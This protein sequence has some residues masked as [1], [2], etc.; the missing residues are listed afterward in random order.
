VALARRETVPAPF[1][2]QTGTGQFKLPDLGA[3]NAQLEMIP[4][5]PSRSQ[6]RQLLASSYPLVLPYLP[7]AYE[8]GRGSGILFEAIY[9]RIPVICSEANIFTHWLREYGLEDFIFSPYNEISLAK[10]ILFF[11]EQDNIEERF[12]PLYD[13]FAAENGVNKFFDVLIGVENKS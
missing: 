8:Q 2:F 1:R 10:K 3:A 11:F 9:N 4:G 5:N 6:Y 12:A 13:G 7:D